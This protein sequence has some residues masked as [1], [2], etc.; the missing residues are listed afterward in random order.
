MEAAGPELFVD[1]NGNYW[2]VPFSLAADIASVNA[3]SGISYHLCINH[4]VGSPNEVE[5]QSAGGAP[6]ALLP[7]LSAKCAASFKKNVN[8]WV[9]EAPKLSMVQPYDMFLSDPRISASMLL[10]K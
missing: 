6:S 9:S 8:I 4:V 2:D 7:G 5:T 10:G 3:D 1:Q